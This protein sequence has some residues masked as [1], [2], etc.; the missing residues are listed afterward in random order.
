MQDWCP[1]A[2]GP[3][4]GPHFAR[5]GLTTFYYIKGVS[6]LASFAA[7]L[8][9]SADSARYAALAAQTTAT[10]HAALY[11]ATHSYYEDG[12]P[13]SQLAA[14]DL[15]GA[16]PSASAGAFAALVSELETGARSGAP[17]SPTGGIVFQK[18]AYPQL[19]AGGRMDLA[20]DLLLARSEPSIGYWFND[21]IQTTP[22]TTLW[23]RWI[24]NASEPTGTSFNHI[25]Y[26]GCKSSRATATCAPRSP[27][28]GAN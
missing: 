8:G 18:L 2:D 7:A 14:L 13:V 23:E 28:G 4:S 10:Y 1:Y 16:S 17:R 12:Y 25:M 9:N 5:L 26:G 27:W 21:T 24:M 15:G 11:N 20:I 22:A 6:A 3:A 19:D